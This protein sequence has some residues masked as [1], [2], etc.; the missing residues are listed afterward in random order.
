MSLKQSAKDSAN[1]GENAG[2]LDRNCWRRG[3]DCACLRIDIGADEVFIF[4]YQQFLGAQHTRQP[5]SETLIISFSSHE[6]TV[7]GWKLSEIASALQD[8]SIAWIKT[9]PARYR[10]FPDKNGPWITQIDLKAV[11]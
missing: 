5:E 9:I 8:L 3:R 11:A 7:S 1:E 2:D 6:I 10:G 4:P